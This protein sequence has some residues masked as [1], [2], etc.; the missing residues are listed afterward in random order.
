MTENAFFLSALLITAPN[1][2]CS[3]VEP[4]TGSIGIPNQISE[5]VCKNDT[6]VDV[7]VLF[8]SQTGTSLQNYTETIRDLYRTENSIGEPLL[9][10]LVL[11]AA[12][13]VNAVTEA[14][15]INYETERFVASVMNDRKKNA[16]R[17][18]I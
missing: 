3:L 2:A 12:D 11:P 8:N 14:L 15:P 4:S 7:N 9:E 16:T 10:K 13:I 18:R 5:L 6:A 1:T 17:R